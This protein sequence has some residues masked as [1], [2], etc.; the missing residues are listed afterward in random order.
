MQPAWPLCVYTSHSRALLPSSLNKCIA[1]CTHD[2]SITIQIESTTIS[3]HKHKPSYLGEKN[4]YKTNEDCL[5]TEYTYR[6]RHLR[7]D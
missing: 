1:M 6:N 3:V 2:T 4:C 7:I 5:Y